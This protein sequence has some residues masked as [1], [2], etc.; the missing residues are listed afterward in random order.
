MG[1]RV[2][3]ARTLLHDPEVLIMDE[4]AS[5]LDP[6]GRIEMRKMI[7][8]LRDLGKTIMLSSHILPELS[9]VCDLVGIIEKGHLLSQGSVKEITASLRKQ[10]V[11]SIMIQSDIERATKLCQENP[12]VRKVTAAGNELRVIFAG[13]R[14]DIA[15]L[16]ADLVG[17]GVRLIRLAEEEG[18]LE[19]AFLQVTGQGAAKSAENAK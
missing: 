9:S 1:K 15:D 3:L 8:R 17:K 18:S 7:Q 4:P 2:A 5:G 10:M 13:T 12:N 11:L 16:T 19:E 6:Y 14:G